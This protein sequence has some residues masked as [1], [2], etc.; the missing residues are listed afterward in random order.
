M[1]ACSL[2]C[3]TAKLEAEA[4]AMEAEI[5]A[6]EGKLVKAS[7]QRSPPSAVAAIFRLAVFGTNALL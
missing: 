2:A 3:Q 5:A 1:V 4:K 6:E 7:P